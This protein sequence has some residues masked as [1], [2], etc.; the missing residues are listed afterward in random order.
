[1]ISIKRAPV[2]HGPAAWAD[3]L[4][5]IP[6]GQS[7]NDDITADVLVVGAGF[8]GL[9]AARRLI[10]IDANLSV[11][12][13]EAG[14]IAEGGTGRNSGFMIDIPHD[15]ASENYGGGTEDQALITLN[16]AAQSFAAQMVD[17]YDVPSDFFDRCGK[18]NGAASTTADVH[19]TT[20]MRHLSTLGEPSERLDAQ[21]MQRVTGSRY[22]R[23]GLYTPGT[24]LLQ[25][26]GYIRGIAN[27]LRRQGVKIFEQ[28]PVINL[29]KG[30]SARTNTGSVSAKNV[31]LSVNGHLE[32]FGFYEQ[33]LMHIF[34]FGAMTAPLQPGTIQ[35]Q[36][37]WGITPSDPMGTTVRRIDGPQGGDRIVVRSCAA[38]RPGMRAT[39]GDLRRAKSVM[40]RKL[41]V[42]F[43]SLDVPLEHVWAGHLCLS[44]NGVSVMNELEKGLFSACV[45]NGLGTT[46]G[47][48]TGI[49]AAEKVMGV[50]SDITRYFD[51]QDLPTKLPPPSIQTIAGNAVLRWKEHQARSE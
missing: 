46:R 24:I 38:L 8:A 26:A 43:P 35:G 49:G 33:R 31:I 36:T 47:T 16:R 5:T 13:L 14:R 41:K 1:M 3:I 27:G 44:R 32:S 51:A 12:V 50:T 22:Y 17:E 6:V 25:P 11:V 29:S 21:E 39:E 28:S 23:S 2:H 4:P 20:F 37:R 42:R 19:N 30:W 45:Q 10:E 18:I 48:L 40:A 15:L 34:L 9:S 7:L